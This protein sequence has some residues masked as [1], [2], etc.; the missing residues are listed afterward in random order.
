MLLPRRHVSSVWSCLAP[1]QPGAI[2]WQWRPLDRLGAV[3]PDE[4][5]IEIAVLRAMVVI[6]D[7]DSE[8]CAHAIHRRGIIHE[9]RR[10]STHQDHRLPV[11]ITAE[12]AQQRTGGD[13][14][15]LERDIVEVA[16]RRLA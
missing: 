10:I 13:D 11:K 16:I 1:A 6:D 8:A 15:G 4:A 5:R 2:A 14:R 3:E 12:A 9:D 7:V